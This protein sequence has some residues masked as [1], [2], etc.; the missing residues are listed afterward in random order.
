[1]YTDP[2]KA[3]SAIGAQGW[4]LE[5]MPNDAPKGAVAL[6]SRL[7]EEGKEYAFLVKIQTKGKIGFALRQTRLS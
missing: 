3:H 7:G 4:E 6:Y 2:L 5:H 1:M